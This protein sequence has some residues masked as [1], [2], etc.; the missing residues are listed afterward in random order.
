M[1]DLAS[2]DD[3]TEDEASEDT[4]NNDPV[5]IHAIE[6]VLRE[7]EPPTPAF[8]EADHAEVA[9]VADLPGPPPVL[10]LQLR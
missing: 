10:R 6:P 3:M 1:L 9:G 2:D 8:V 4:P 5:A 7:T